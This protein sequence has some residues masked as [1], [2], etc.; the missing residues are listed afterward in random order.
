MTLE[1]SLEEQFE[2]HRQRLIDYAERLMSTKYR[3]MLAAEALAAYQDTGLVLRMFTHRS[4][5]LEARPQI[6]RNV[7]ER[8][9]PNLGDQAGMTWQK[10]STD[11]K[12]SHFNTLIIEDA[13]ELHA[14]CLNTKTFKLNWTNFRTMLMAAN[15]L[16]PFELPEVIDG[17]RLSAV[18]EHLPKRNGELEPRLFQIAFYDRD[19]T[20][21]FHTI[22]L[23]PYY[24]MARTARPAAAPQ[25]AP[26]IEETFEIQLLGE[27]DAE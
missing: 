25:P 6:L 20:F 16:I 4:S 13:L 7:M 23:M 2:R 3:M 1:P 17:L 11:P 15:P 8:I 19:M 26:E 22:D 14:S 12:G 18:I 9:A 21:Q 5:E 10:N 27:E 24:E